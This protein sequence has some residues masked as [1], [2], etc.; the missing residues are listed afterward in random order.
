[1]CSRA[2]ASDCREGAR[3]SEDSDETLA[4]A[5]ESLGGCCVL[6]GVSVWGGGVSGCF[7]RSGY[8]VA[9]GRG[10]K[11]GGWSRDEDDSSKCDQRGELFSSSEWGFDG[12]MADV[13]GYCWRKEGYD[14]GFGEGEVHYGEPEG[15]DAELFVVGTG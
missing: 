12:E 13:A 2:D 15:E 5:P 4:D 10:I 14:G 7:G 8:G 9:G 6:D 11:Q 1:M 3:C